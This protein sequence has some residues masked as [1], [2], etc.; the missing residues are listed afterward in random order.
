MASIVIMPKQGLLMEEGVI[1]NWIVKEGGK[2]TEGEPL[3]EMETDKLTITMDSTATGTVLK[4]LHPEGDTVPI[5]KPIAI[6][7]E[8]GEDISGLLAQCGEECHESNE[9][10]ECHESQESDQTPRI[11]EKPTSLPQGMQVASPRAKMRAEE[12]GLDVNA[13]KG[14]GPDGYVIEKDVLA[15]IAAGRKATPLAKN[16]AAAEGRSLE[17]VQGSGVNG[18]ITAADLA[19]EA[20]PAAAPAASRG[21]KVVPMNAMR[22]AI[23]RNMTASKNNNVQACHFIDVDM[24]A[25]MALRAKY[26]AADIKISFNDIIIR[27]CAQALKEFPIVNA[28]VDGNNI[29]YHDAVNIGNAVS[30]PNGLIVP[31]IKDAD[32]I[33]LKNIAKVSADLVAKARNGALTEADYHGGTF[34]VTSLGMFDIDYFIARI[35]PP[36]SAILSVGKIDKKPVVVTNADGEDSIVIRPICTLGL[37]YNHCIIDGADA[38]KFLKAVKNY[39]QNPDMMI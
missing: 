20:A 14:T 34:T 23:A 11:E 17:G 30:V 21:D 18:K 15:A 16:I 10:H 5:T 2:A 29:V 13:I 28:S 7:G 4:I 19:C 6:I 37:S 12:N 36:E 24:T 25:A 39:L 9:S 32:I 38:A 33:G 31:V 8:P 3:F 22:K 27:V 35:N 26:K 1:V